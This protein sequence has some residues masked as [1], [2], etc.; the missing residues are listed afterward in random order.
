MD[1]NISALSIFKLLH[2]FSV[3]IAVGGVTTFAIWR[4]LAQKNEQAKLTIL[5]GVYSL[6]QKMVFPSYILLF[7]TGFGASGIGKIPMTLPWVLISIILSVIALALAY[8]LYLPSLKKQILALESGND[9][10][11][12]AKNAGLAAKIIVAS[13]HIALIFM[14]LK[15]I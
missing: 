13:S 3:V 5:K 11:E 10:S 12:Y 15:P 9:D 8:G 7:I 4:G 14:I 6:S 2:I 1:F